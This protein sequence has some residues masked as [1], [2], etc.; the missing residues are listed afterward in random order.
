M[1]YRPC[2]I[3]FYRP[4]GLEMCVGGGGGGQESARLA[5]KPREPLGG[6]GVKH[7]RKILKNRVSLMP[8]PAFCS[9]VLYIDQVMKEKK[10]LE[11]L[12]KENLKR[13][14][15]QLLLSVSG[16]FSI[17]FRILV[18]T[19]L[20]LFCNYP[21]SNEFTLR[22]LQLC[23]QTSKLDSELRPIFR[24]HF[25]IFV[26]T[27]PIVSKCEISYYIYTFIVRKFQNFHDYCRPDLKR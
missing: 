10:I 6:S 18:R 16:C 4:T 23:P 26:R 15:A 21:T 3:V 22:N 13:K 1:Q 2:P 9:G 11:I 12:M 7:P 27:P 24:I 8:S 17:A 14:I 5:L 20:M 19:Y 25:A